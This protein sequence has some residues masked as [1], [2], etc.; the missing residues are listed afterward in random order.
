MS[1]LNSLVEELQSKI[2]KQNQIISKFKE[3][4]KDSAE[5]LN[6]IEEK[7]K[8][9]K[10]LKTTILD[11]NNDME[12]YKAASTGKAIGPTDEDYQAK[13]TEITEKEYEIDQLKTQ[14]TEAQQK[15]KELE[16]QIPACQALI[17]DLQ[18]QLAA[19]AQAPAYSTTSSTPSSAPEVDEGFYPKPSML[20]QSSA[21][22]S[23]PGISPPPSTSSPQ[24][25]GT[26]SSPGE[27]ERQCPQCGASGFAIKEFEDKTKILSYTPRIYAKK[28]ICTKCSYEF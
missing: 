17:Q 20:S 19:K 12:K 8:E 14:L 27:M 24:V 1:D 11:L 22:P 23:T 13:I 28:R 25:S 10:I 5:F 6:K 16:A 4:T 3:Q 2:N 26:Y 7:D 21:V 9:I 15:I 18:Q